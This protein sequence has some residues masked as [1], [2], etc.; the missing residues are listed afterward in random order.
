MAPVIPPLAAA[1]EIGP[2]LGV[3]RLSTVQCLI[4][5]MVK[6]TL[7]CTMSDLFYHSSPTRQE[8][9]GCGILYCKSK[10]AEAFLAI[11][12]NHPRSRQSK[13]FEIM[14]RDAFYDC[15]SPQRFCYCITCAW[16]G[17]ASEMNPLSQP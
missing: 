16:D 9:M 3:C 6:S 4:M 2:V 1:S 7:L 5:H 17:E 13:H 8:R 12:R 15:R 14:M 10:R 11:P